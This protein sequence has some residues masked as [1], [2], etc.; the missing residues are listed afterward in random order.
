MTATPHRVHAD[1]KP[2]QERVFEILQAEA[3]IT[4]NVRIAVIEFCTECSEHIGSTLTPS[5][6]AVHV[7]TVHQ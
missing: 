5:A 1:V 3:V 7:L 2:V 4:G 6:Q